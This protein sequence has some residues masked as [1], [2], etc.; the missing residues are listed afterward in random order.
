MHWRRTAA[1]AAGSAFQ[2]GFQFPQRRIA[3]PADGVDW[4]A[5]ARLAPVAFD[6]QPAETAVEALACRGRGLCRPAIAFHADGPGFRLRAVGGANGFPGI[7]PH[8]TKLDSSFT[9]CTYGASPNPEAP[10]DNRLNELRR[11]IS[12]LRREM[13]GLEASIRDLVNNDR[14][15]TESSLRLMGMRQ[16]LTA[17]VKEW[18]L[19]GGGERLPTIQERLRE[20]H[21]PLRKRK[22]QPKPQPRR[23]VEKRRLV[24][25]R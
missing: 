20:N 22:A 9:F 17:S 1:L 4:L 7:F 8:S 21:R 15:C 19:L 16:E 13:L 24:A 14:D 10:M 2:R 6:F 11:K 25:R 5:R 3:R 12:T 23:K 18:A